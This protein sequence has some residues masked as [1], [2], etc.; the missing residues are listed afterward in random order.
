MLTRFDAAITEARQRIASGDV[1]GA[2][3]A[4][5]TARDIDPTAPSLVEISAR[6]NELLRQSPA[7]SRQAREADRP[8]PKREASV[9][10]PAQAPPPVAPAPPPPVRPAPEPQPA[11]VTPVI[12]A[13]QTEPVAPPKPAPPPPPPAAERKEPDP[14]HAAAAQA[15]QDETALR[16]LVA[17]YA[18]AIEA[19]DLALFRSIKP[20]LSREEERRLQDGFR[21]VTSQRVTATVISID[22][23]GDEATIAVRRRDTIDAGGRQ[24]TSESQQSI[25]AA[26]SGAGWVIVAI[27]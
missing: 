13:P 5:G 23:R 15:E 12:P 14:A 9:P 11:P 2:A 22:R 21:A 6:L 4:L 27:R 18:R 7:P 19:K 16:R 8:E 24:Q 1:S 26:R 20:N 17:S 3:R 25:V 10:A